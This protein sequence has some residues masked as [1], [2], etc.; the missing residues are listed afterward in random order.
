M[1]LTPEQ[2][3]IVFGPGSGRS[4][5]SQRSSLADDRRPFHQS[6]W[7]IPLL[8][9]TLD[10]SSVRDAIDAM[11]SLMRQGRCARWNRPILEILTTIIV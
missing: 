6:L 9:V 10:R 8:S 7:L 3:R 11:A 2:S 5:S 1:R 4:Q